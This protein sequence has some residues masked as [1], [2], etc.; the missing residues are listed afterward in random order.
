[1]KISTSVV[2]VEGVA[3]S[4]ARGDGE[5]LSQTRVGGGVGVRLNLERIR[6]L[7]SQPPRVI[8]EAGES[9]PALQEG[10]R[11]V[12]EAMAL[13]KRDSGAPPEGV[14]NEEGAVVFSYRDR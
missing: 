11:E 9:L 8:G 12:L 13:L 7:A 3:P 2:L 4:S 14:R 10:A 1:V 6:Q 5:E